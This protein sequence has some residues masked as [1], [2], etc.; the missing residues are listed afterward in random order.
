[1]KH[2]S[3]PGWAAAAVLFMGR[4]HLQAMR[5]SAGCGRPPPGQLLYPVWSP[6]CPRTGGDDGAAPLPGP[7]QALRG[8]AVTGEVAWGRGV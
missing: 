2:Q 8:R 7:A 5:T 3:S 4:P 1:M 6:L